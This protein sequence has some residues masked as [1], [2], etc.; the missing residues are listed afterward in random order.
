MENKTEELELVGEPMDD[1]PM[2]FRPEVR[3]TFTGSGCTEFNKMLANKSR[4]FDG[5]TIQRY[6]PKPTQPEQRWYNYSYPEDIVHDRKKKKKRG[7]LFCS[8]K[9]DWE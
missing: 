6:R 8:Y 1:E 2:E 5:T 7:G 3:D 9:P 4:K